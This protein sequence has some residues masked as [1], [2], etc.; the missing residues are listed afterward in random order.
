MTDWEFC[1]LRKTEMASFVCLTL[2]VEDFIYSAPR[3]GNLQSTVTAQRACVFIFLLSLCGFCLPY[4]FFTDSLLPA[5][6]ICEQLL[7]VAVS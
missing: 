3:H 7:H 4:G 1:L 5:S 6:D 2:E